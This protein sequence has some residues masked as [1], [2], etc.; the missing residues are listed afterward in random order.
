MRLPPLRGMINHQ[1]YDPTMISSQSSKLKERMWNKREF[2]TAI[3]S[4]P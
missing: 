2:R 4:L 3:D 1:S